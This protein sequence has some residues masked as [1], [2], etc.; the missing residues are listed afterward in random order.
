MCGKNNPQEHYRGKS[1]GILLDV[2]ENVKYAKLILSSLFLLYRDISGGRNYS[3]IPCFNFK[4]GERYGKDPLIY[5][6]IVV[7]S[8]VYQNKPTPIDWKTITSPCKLDLKG[9]PGHCL[10]P[11]L[12]DKTACGLRC[13]SQS[14]VRVQP[15]MVNGCLVP[16]EQAEA[17]CG[18]LIQNAAAQFDG[19]RPP[20]TAELSRLVHRLSAQAALRPDL[21]DDLRYV[22]KL[23]KVHFSAL[24]V[25]N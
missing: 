19:K 6:N 8:L 25:T 5:S 13:F 16:V 1:K 2:Q 9:K 14:S 24:K 12:C 21:R 10:S 18:G 3:P 7:R 23:A 17:F 4:N 20:T 22:I 15:E 11:K